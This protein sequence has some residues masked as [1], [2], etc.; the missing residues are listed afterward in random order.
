VADVSAQEA[1]SAHPLD[2]VYVTQSVV[3]EILAMPTMDRAAMYNTILR[4]PTARS[5]W[6]FPFEAPG[7]PP[8]TKYSALE[9]DIPH[10]PAVIYR[11]ALEGENGAFRVVALMDRDAFYALTRGGLA[12]NKVV[13]GVAAAVAAAGTISAAGIVRPVTGPISGAAPSQA[14]HPGA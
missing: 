9:P 5:S 14:G 8:D 6:P 7:D 3:D 1:D 13:Q 11:P 10:A 2:E 4:V 12:G